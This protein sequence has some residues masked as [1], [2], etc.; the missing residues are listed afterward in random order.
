M[1]RNLKAMGLALVAVLALGAVVASSA[2]AST[3]EAESYPVTLTGSQIGT[4]VFTTNA[5]T[6]SCTNATYHGSS[7]AAS[8]TVEVAPTY[9]GC[10][11]FGFINTPIDV[12]GCKYLFHSGAKNSADNYA[13]TV[14]IVCPKVETEG[15]TIHNTSIVVTGAGCT[16]T[17]GSQSGLSGITFVDNTTASP[18]KDVTTKIAISQKIAYTV[19]AGCSTTKAGS[20]TNGSYTGEA[21]VTGDVPGKEPAVPVGVA[22]SG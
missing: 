19:D 11:A 3:F 6:V 17:I 5:G 15:G 22:V 18:K 7:S 21:T 20:F 14:D 16:V 4:D 10:T 8:S 13:G 12:N 1:I 2:S 9:S